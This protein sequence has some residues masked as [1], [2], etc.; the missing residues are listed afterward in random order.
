[1]PKENNVSNL[2]KYLSGI[3]ASLKPITDCAEDE[4][5]WMWSIEKYAGK[6][7]VGYSDVDLDIVYINLKFISETLNKRTNNKI[8]KRYIK[9]TIEGLGLVGKRCKIIERM[10][11]DGEYR[12]LVKIKGEKINNF[13]LFLL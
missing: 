13:K 8:N 5:L 12:E 9:K 4:N 1:M 10:T 2:I 3:G 7:I 6:Y 11:I